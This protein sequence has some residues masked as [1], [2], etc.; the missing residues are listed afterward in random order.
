MRTRTVVPLVLLLS[1][2]TQPLDAGELRPSLTMFRTGEADPALWDD[3]VILPEDKFI[4]GILQGP[5]DHDE[6]PAYRD[7]LHVYTDLSHMVDLE[8]PTL[9]DEHASTYA[10][11]RR[12]GALF[13]GGDDID[14][15]DVEQG[16]IGDCYL[17]AAFSAVF[18]ADEERFVRDGLIREQ[19]DM[20]GNPTHYAVRF[21]DAWGRPQ[22]IMVDIDIARRHDHPLYIR[23]LDSAADG[24]EWA[25]PLVEKA[26]AKWHGGYQKIGDGGW[27]GDVM[28]ALSGAKATHRMIEDMSDSSLVTAIADAV[29]EHRP[30]VAGTFGKDAGVDYSGTGVHAWHAYS[31]HGTLLRDEV[32]YV[33]L[34]NPWGE[35]EPSPDL[36]DG[37]DDGRFLMSL[38][39]FRRLYE[40]ITFGGGFFDDTTAPSAPGDLALQEIAGDRAILTFEATGDDGTKGLAARYDVRV[41]DEEVTSANFYGAT[42]VPVASPEPPGTVETIEVPLPGTPAWVAVRV[43]DESGNVSP[44]SPVLEISE[45]AV[46]LAF[47]FEGSTSDWSTTGLWHRTDADANSGTHSFWFGDEETVSYDATWAPSGSLT[48]PVLDLTAFRGPV[49]DW[50]QLLDVETS[51]ARDLAVVEVATSD[52][53]YADWTE[54]WSKDGNAITVWREKTVDL[55]DYAGQRVKI[56]W[57]FDAVD[58]DDNTGFGWWVDDVSIF[59][60]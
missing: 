14:Y 54:V 48:S 10:Y 35:D 43:E 1:A 56:R 39:D 15:Q 36:I 2:C 40:D 19:T 58:T 17:A 11:S 3:E 32:P 4:P 16:A 45:P 55:D 49:L 21:Y 25:I 8:D 33:K 6:A 47:D 51:A 52:G 22:D 23:S 30:V 59:E 44:I 12:A 46:D 20:D 57:R 9:L 26:Y 53:G 42:K 27:S 50:I 18:F 34:R 41:S 29:A 60:Q 31:V 7:A 5:L 24:E 37:L 38:S 13:R 28:Q